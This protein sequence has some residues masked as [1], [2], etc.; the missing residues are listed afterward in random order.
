MPLPSRVSPKGLD[1]VFVLALVGVVFLGFVREVYPSE[2]TALAA[3]AVLLA[4]GI[5]ETGDFLTVFSSSAPMTIA[6]MFI[7]STALERTGVL[8]VI[9][10]VL[11]R[12]ARGSFLRATLLMMVGTMGASPLI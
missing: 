3:S 1:H 4:T 10:D 7:I 2:V 12:Q 8:M 9:G 11:K 5:I 6:M